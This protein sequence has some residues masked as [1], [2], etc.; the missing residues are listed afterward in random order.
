MPIS[1]ILLAA[2]AL[3]WWQPARADHL[4]W[5]QPFKTADGRSCCADIDCR[6]AEVEVLHQ[7]HGLVRLGRVEGDEG[8]VIVDMQLPSGSVYALPPVADALL[9]EGFNGYWCWDW[10]GIE[11]RSAENTR[12][13]FFKSGNF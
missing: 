11:V 5:M 10:R 12:C 2:Y 13:V 9:P 3:L 1:L 8:R 6:P 4:G 7:S